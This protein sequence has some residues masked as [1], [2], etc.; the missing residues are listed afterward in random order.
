MNFL[1]WSSQ[2]VLEVASGF[3]EAVSYFANS[4]PDTIFV[5]TDPQKPCLERLRELAQTHE[6]LVEPV[7]LNIFSASQWDKVAKQGPFDGMLV[8]NLIHLIPYSGTYELLDRASALLAT[9]KGFLA[10]HGAFL[11][12]GMF[13][14]ESDR[15]FDADIKSRDSEWG[16]RDLEQVVRIAGE[17]GFKKEEVREMRAGN[18]MLILRRQ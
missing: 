11:R 1:D 10:I 14:S 6:N 7:E 17:K 4:H 2:I 12:E 5:P 16:L 9:D 3:G 8:F 15:Q 18:W 13:M